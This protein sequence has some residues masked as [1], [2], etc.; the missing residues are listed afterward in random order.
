MFLRTAHI[1]LRSVLAQLGPVGMSASA[2]L[3]GRKQTSGA[4]FKLGPIGACP[5]LTGPFHWQQKLNKPL[6]FRAFLHF[7]SAGKSAGHQDHASSPSASAS[8]VVRYRP[9]PSHPA[10]TSVTTRTPLMSSRDA[11][12]YASFLIFVKRNFRKRT[13]YTGIELN[14]LAKLRFSEKRS[15]SNW[16]GFDATSSSNRAD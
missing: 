15:A 10:S 5:F 8:L 2:P 6:F 12:K 7:S 4:S 11:A 3:L 13:R 1:S 9:R 16:T 14:W